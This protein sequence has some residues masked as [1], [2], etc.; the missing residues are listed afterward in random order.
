MAAQRVEQ[1]A[2]VG[3]GADLGIDAAVVDHIVAVRAAR[4][5]FQEGRG[6]NVAHAELGEVRHERGRVGEAE[7]L[8]KLQPVGGNRNALGTKDNESLKNDLSAMLAARRCTRASP[9]QRS[10]LT[11]SLRRQLGCSSTVPGRF[12]CSTSSNT[13]SGCTITSFDGVRA[14]RR[15]RPGRR[16]VEAV[17]LKRT[18]EPLL[19]PPPQ[20]AFLLGVDRQPEF[21]LQRE[22]VPSQKP[23][24]VGRSWVLRQVSA[25]RG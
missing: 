2:Q 3:L 5:R 17:A 4:P 15:V 14:R 24:H 8:V 11:G 6:I 12:A 18:L 19:V 20:A 22:I 23:R 1:P 7:L 21:L 10:R 16:G 9:F 13:S 25:S